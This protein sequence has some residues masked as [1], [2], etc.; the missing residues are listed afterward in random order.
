MYVM[1]YAPDLCSFIFYSIFLHILEARA[2]GPGP[3]MCKHMKKIVL[4]K[5]Y[6]AY[7]MTYLYLFILDL[8]LFWSSWPIVFNTFAPI[9]ANW[10]IIPLHT[11]WI[12][13]LPSAATVM[14]SQWKFNNKA[15]ICPGTIHRPAWKM[16]E[17]PRLSKTLALLEKPRLLCERKYNVRRG[18]WQTN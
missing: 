18:N 12:T 3:N 14:M 7:N 5:W 2:P 10:Y 17:Y 11:D 16:W 15:T 13:T 4:T 1:L 9:W 8:I 6:G